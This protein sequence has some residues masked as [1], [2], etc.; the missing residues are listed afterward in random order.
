MLPTQGR[1]ERGE[2]VM[3][4]EEMGILSSDFLYVGL[5]GGGVMCLKEMGILS[6]D[7]FYMWGWEGGGSCV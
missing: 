2:G 5:G 1:E 4:V 6:S 7:F 3:C